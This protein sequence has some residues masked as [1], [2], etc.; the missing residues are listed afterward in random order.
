[1]DLDDGEVFDG[2]VYSADKDECT[3]AVESGEDALQVCG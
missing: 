3:A 2:A 1:M